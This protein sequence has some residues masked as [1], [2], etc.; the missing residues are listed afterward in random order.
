MM[1]PFYQTNERALTWQG[2]A[3]GSKSLVGFAE[4]MESINLMINAASK[5]ILT[6]CNHQIDKRVVML[7]ILE[8]RN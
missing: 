4:R 1:V 7:L 5:P 2:W 6:G 8:D 3:A